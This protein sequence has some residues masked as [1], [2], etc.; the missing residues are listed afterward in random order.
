MNARLKNPFLISGYVS[1]EYFC[2]R[3]KEKK[4]ILANIEN[5]RNTALI[6][7]RRMG[8]T[9][10]IDHCFYSKTIQKEYN[11]FYIDIYSTGSLREFVLLF[12]KAIFEKLK[13][14]G[15][16][17]FDKFFRV[18]TSLRPAFKL[19]QITGNAVFD[20][21]IGEIITPEVSI[22]QI[23]KYLENADKLCIVAFDEFQ[24]IAKYPEKNME[25]L[26]RSHIQRC[27]NARFIF[28][29]SEQHMMQDIFLKS[30][31]PFYQSVSFVDLQPIALYEY[32]AF[33]EKHFSKNDKQLDKN[34]IEWVYNSFDGHTWYM[35]TIFNAIYSYTGVGE[36]VTD[37]IVKSSVKDTVGIYQ[38]A[39]KRIL[40]DLTERQKELLIAIAK[41]RKATEITS[42][43]F[44]KKHGLQSSSSVQ[45]A[46]KTLL[47]KEIVVKRDKTYMVDDKFLRIWIE[48]EYGPGYD[49]A[50]R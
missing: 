43:A 29:G 42:A 25:A 22:E 21:G 11:T 20:I 33:V 17:F 40:S 28:S 9:G 18:I 4:A 36:T 49:F 13:G 7:P 27:N 34:T 14:N 45:S 12:G 35:Q 24:Q 16:K 23:F 10:L 1:P 2:D 26:L 46:I 5:G 37:Q 3:N 32:T 44:I 48:N 15:Q 6:S 47:V 8:K 39:Y 31:R 41:E 38:N 19:D 30:S 50:I